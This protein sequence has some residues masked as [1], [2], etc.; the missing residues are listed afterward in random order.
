MP[1]LRC[2]AFSVGDNRF[3]A[4]GLAIDIKDATR[5]EAAGDDATDAECRKN[6]HPTDRDRG[7]GRACLVAP[8]CS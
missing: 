5:P 4:T 7:S 2:S 8:R 1:S 6:V 3:M